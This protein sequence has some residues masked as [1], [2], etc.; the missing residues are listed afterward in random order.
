MEN[1]SLKLAIIGLGYWGPNFVR[2]VFENDNLELVYCCD[3]DKQSLG[4]IHKRYPALNLI[5]DYKEILK[6]KSVKAVIVVT[7]PA[8]HYKIVKDCLVAGKDVLVEK[9][10][11]LTLQEADDLTIVAKNNGRILMVDH[12]FQ[13]NPA[14]RKLKEIIDRRR[15]GRIFYLS[16]SYTALGPVRTDVNALWDLAPHFFYTLEFL[17]GKKPL[18][19][20]AFGGSYLKKKTEDV[21]YITLGFPNNI[22]VNLHVSWLYPYKV[23]NLVVVGSK[24][25]AVFDDISVDQKIRVYD[26]GAYYDTHSSDYPTILKVIYREGDLLIPKIE[27]REPLTEVL[28]TFTEAIATRQLKESDGEAGKTVIE[29]LE[30]AEKSLKKHG[31]KIKII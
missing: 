30:A 24:K 12:I 22:L 27:V 28:R 25:M 18:W 8:T 10:M 15:L 19:V 11:T 9:P 1:K 31:Q 13:F 3:L 16:G 23:R 20:A 7:P 5:T 26:K 17:L 14:I 2:T 6:D 21:I 4:K 29:V